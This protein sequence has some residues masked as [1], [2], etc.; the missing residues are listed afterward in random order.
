MTGTLRRQVTK[1][2]FHSGTLLAPWE[3]HFMKNLALAAA[4]LFALSSTALAAPSF[5][6][7]MEGEACLD[8]SAPPCA[9]DYSWPFVLMINADR[10]AV[11]QDGYGTFYDM[12]W[13]FGGGRLDLGFV[14]YP[15]ITWTGMKSGSCMQ[16]VW[17]SSPPGYDPYMLQWGAC[18]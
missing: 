1:R 2:Q 16:G 13:T 3:A 12:E 7:I 14:A 5:P 8:G 4:G 9:A 10:T 18:W 17:N 6:I 11:L 15:F